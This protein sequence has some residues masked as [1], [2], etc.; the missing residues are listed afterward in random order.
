MACVLPQLM[1]QLSV[2]SLDFLPRSAG[3]PWWTEVTAVEMGCGENGE[4]KFGVSAHEKLQVYNQN[5]APCGVSITA[6]WVD[7]SFGF[8]FFFVKPHSL[9]ETQPPLQTTGL[10]YVTESLLGHSGLFL[11]LT[12]H[13]SIE[14][15]W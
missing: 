6:K 13:V 9:T 11:V 2:S 14:L 7:N 1:S 10:Y 12:R 4:A 15:S 5:E 3:V 8:F